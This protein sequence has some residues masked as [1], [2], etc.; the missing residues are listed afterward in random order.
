MQPPPP[1]NNKVTSSS[2][3]SSVPPHVMA[4]T[5]RPCLVP[6]CAMMTM[7]PPPRPHRDLTH[8]PH[9]GRMTMASHLVPPHATTTMTSSVP[10]HMMMMVP[11]PRTILTHCATCTHTIQYMPYQHPHPPDSTSPCQFARMCAHAA[12]VPITLITLIALL[13]CRHP[14]LPCYAVTIPHQPLLSLVT[15]SYCHHPSLPR[16]AV[17]IPRSLVTP[18]LSLIALSLPRTNSVSSSLSHPP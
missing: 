6:P 5:P 8:H 17:A 16:C 18:S 4:M 12:H 14:S 2:L 7:W 9:T 15:S 3:T 1:C 10:P 13:H 11:F